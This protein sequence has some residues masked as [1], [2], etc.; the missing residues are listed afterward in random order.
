VRRFGERGEGE[1]AREREAAG[2]APPEGGGG[3][4][5]RK[6]RRSLSVLPS[7]GR[8]AGSQRPPVEIDYKK[9]PMPQALR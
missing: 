8:K 7:R 5:L 9:E 2:P 4:R 6:E 1:R 3:P